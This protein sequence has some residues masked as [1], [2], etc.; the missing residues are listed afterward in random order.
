MVLA[1]DLEEV[2]EV[3]C[4]GMNADQVF[5][6]LGDG[7]WYGCDGEVLRPLVPS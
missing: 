5:V 4:C 6:R 1:T 7:I 3:C 2:K